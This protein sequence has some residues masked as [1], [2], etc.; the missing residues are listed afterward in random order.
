MPELWY[1]Y[2]VYKSI[3]VHGR[4]CFNEGLWFSNRFAM[5][6]KQ[7]LY[8][9]LHPSF[10]ISDSSHLIIAYILSKYRYDCS[11]WSQ[12]MKYNYM[13]EVINSK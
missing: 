6:F 4:N 10:L 11:Q 8:D 3:L 7:N 13:F 2:N 9:N 1:V 5:S 12:M